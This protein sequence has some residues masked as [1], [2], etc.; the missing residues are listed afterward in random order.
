MDPKL[1]Q[2]AAKGDI[3]PFKEIAKDEHGSIVTDDTNN[4]VLHVNIMA[5]PPTLQIEE[6]E[7]S[8]IST[9]FVEQILDLCPSLLFQA[10]ANGDSPLH[11]AAKKGHA[12]VVEFLIAFAKKQ[13]I[14]LESGVE[15]RAR[16]MLEL[17]NKEQNTPLHEAVRLRMVDAVKIL[18][19]ADP[20]VPY[21]TNRKG[22]TPLYMAAANG[23]VEIVAEILQ[24]CPSPAHEG[25]D[26]KT[27]LHA[28]V[29]TYPTEVIKQLLEKKRSLTTVQDE[30]GWTPLH[31]AAYSGRRFTSALLLE[32]DKSAAYIGE[33]DRKMTAFHLAAA[34][35]HI[36]VVCEIISSC[37]DC[38]EQVDER[39]WNLLHFAMASSNVF[40]LHSLLRNRSVEMLINKQDVNGSTPL[41]VLAAVCRLLSYEVVPPK[42]GPGDYEALNNS[43]ISVEHVK[44]HGFPE[45]EQ[46]IQE[47]SKNVGCGRY[48]D[49]VI[50]VQKEKLLIDDGEIKEMKP[51]HTLVAALIATVT[52]AAGF[53]LP[54][55]YWGKEGPIPGTPI[56]I[57]SVAF[58]AFVVSDVIAMV[59]SLSAVFIHFLASTKTL[60]Q[61]SFLYGVAHRFIMASMLAMVVAFVTGTYAMLAPSV[62]LSVATCV[63]GLSFI[64]VACFASFKFA[65]GLQQRFLGYL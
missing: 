46:E 35:G 38:C 63:L 47:L 59:L 13:P 43:G 60:L 42:R 9:K 36:W 57:K 29:Y 32:C 25:P 40:Q 17:N 24:N 1:F 33:K 65:Y 52:F 48:P 14:D 19:K 7:I 41:H 56:L 37:P 12:A 5:S 26:G 3:E 11:L 21:S 22:E 62:G 27:A 34:R 53:T 4:T 10:N 55:G 49:G 31:H 50:K 28:A 54:G 45:L 23:S 39:G 8:G 15:S 16:H 20:H 44:V 2:A 6:G 64:L 58:Q 30:Y 61:I 18:I 51:R